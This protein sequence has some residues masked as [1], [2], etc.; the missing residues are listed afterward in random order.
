M[1]FLNDICEMFGSLKVWLCGFCFPAVL[2]FS[3]G[4][5]GDPDLAGET[6]LHPISTWR[7]I[8][9]AGSLLAPVWQIALQL[10]F[11]NLI[12]EYSPLILL[13]FSVALQG[14]SASIRRPAESIRALSPPGCGVFLRLSA[15]FLLME[16]FRFV[17]QLFGVL[18]NCGRMVRP[19]LAPPTCFHWA[20]V[21]TVAVNAGRRRYTL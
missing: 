20:Q 4:G 3:L 8:T 13:L 17:D 2:C 14:G 18:L 16:S 12:L 21:P 9:G 15:F 10:L 6:H 1:R 7:T 19:L 11:V 5:A